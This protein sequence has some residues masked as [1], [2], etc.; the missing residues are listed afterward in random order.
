MSSGSQMGGTEVKV[1]DLGPSHRFHWDFG[2]KAHL[3]PIPLFL[4]VETGMRMFSSQPFS[5]V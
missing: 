1:S 2:E 4:I 3:F 5:C